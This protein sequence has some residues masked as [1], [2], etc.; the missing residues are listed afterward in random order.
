MLSGVIQQPAHSA[1]C[2][3]SCGGEYGM[4]WAPFHPLAWPP[5]CSHLGQPEALSWDPRISLGQ[6]AERRP[7]PARIVLLALG[8]RQ[9]LAQASGA[10]HS[11][12]L[13]C[14]CNRRSVHRD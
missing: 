3:W 1:C 8:L 10:L 11:K 5:V 13:R 2:G 6:H 4:L 14:S 9:S 12:G 7:Q